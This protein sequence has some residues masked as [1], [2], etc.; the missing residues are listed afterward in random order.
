MPATVLHSPKD[1]I[2]YI[3]YLHKFQDNNY[4]FTYIDF[5]AKTSSE[6]DSIANLAD[7]IIHDGPIRTRKRI[8]NKVA[9]EYFDLRG[10][11]CVKVYDRNN[12]AIASGEFSHI[13]FYDESEVS[14]YIAVFKVNGN[15]SNVAEY[16]ASCSMAN[17][18]DRSCIE[19][20]N[21]NL[22]VSI[23]KYL[24]LKPEDSLKVKHYN[25]VRSDTT[26]S[27]I[28]SDTTAYIVETRG[29]QNNLV[30]KSKYSETIMSLFMISKSYNGRPILLTDS[31]YPASDVFWSSLLVFNGT[32]YEIKKGNKLLVK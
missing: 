12:E 32:E 25:L 18:I 21:N 3:N 22:T 15:V 23:I 11:A 27:I 13:E 30:Y 16:F 4:Y 7:S 31:G 9:S 8:P 29:D 6:F 14:N 26:Y 1:S 19:T 2:C 17:F 20:N 24:H 5:N 10:L 28:S